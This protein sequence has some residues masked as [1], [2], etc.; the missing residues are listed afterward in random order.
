MYFNYQADAYTIQHD[1][2]VEMNWPYLV[3]YDCFGT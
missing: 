1:L 2:Q 3:I